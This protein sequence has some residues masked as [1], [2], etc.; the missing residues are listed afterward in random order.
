MKGQQ[1]NNQVT[2]EMNQYTMDSSDMSRE[3][4][5]GDGGDSDALMLSREVSI[6][7]GGDSDALMFGRDDIMGDLDPIRISLADRNNDNSYIAEYQPDHYFGASGGH[8]DDTIL[9]IPSRPD[10]YTQQQLSFSNMQQQEQQFRQVSPQHIHVA[11]RPD[12]LENHKSMT[13]REHDHTINKLLAKELNQ[14]SFQERN[15]INEVIHG[16]SSLYSINETPELIS[17]SIEQLQIEIE[18]NI[19]IQQKLAY[20]TSKKICNQLRIQE[21]QGHRQGHRQSPLGSISIGY[22]NDP[23]FILMFLR[24]EQF[25]VH[26]AALRLVRFM[27]LVYELYGDSAFTQK[28]WE[29]QSVLNKLELD[30]L[31]AGPMQCLQGRDRAGRRIVGQFALDISELSVQSRVSTRTGCCSLFAIR[32]RTKRWCVISISCFRFGLE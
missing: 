2:R 26:K 27:D 9:R 10:H 1:T 23:D 3:M 14:L 13:Q 8:Q 30:V 4:S 15:S 31:R 7:D 22:I 6:G 5:I 19:P 12:F 21:Q 28:V 25:V 20:E 24:R 11:S 16:V 18:Q 17:G 29:S 32:I